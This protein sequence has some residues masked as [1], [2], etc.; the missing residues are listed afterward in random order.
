MKARNKRHKLLMRH[1]MTL[2]FAIPVI[3]IFLAVMAVSYRRISESYRTNIEYSLFQTGNQAVSFLES[4]FQGMWEVSERML[5]DGEIASVLHAEDFLAPKSRRQEYEEYQTL[6]SSMANIG[7]GSPSFRI[8]IYIP[9]SVGY[10]ANRYYIYPLSELG[11]RTEDPPVQDMLSGNGYVWMMGTERTAAGVDVLAT[12]RA[13]VLCRLMNDEAYGKDAS[14]ESAAPVAK[15]AVSEE[16]LRAILDNALILDG[17]SVL[18][19]DGRGQVVLAAGESGELDAVPE[20]LFAETES[21]LSRVR[22]RNKDMYLLSSPAMAYSGWRIAMTVPASRM[23]WLILKYTWYLIPLMLLVILSI[24]LTSILLSRVYT[25]RLEQLSEHMKRLQE[26]DLNTVFDVEPGASDE[27]DR[28]NE[29]FNYM[30]ER[31]RGLMQEHYRMGKSVKTSE[32]RALQAQINPHFLYNTLDLIN[33]MAMDFGTTEIAEIAQN[34]ARFYRLSLNRGRSILTIGEEIEHVEV[35]VNIEN[36][37]FNGAIEL[38]T[39]VSPDLLGLGCPNI[40]L[41]PFVENAI[42]HGIA[43]REEITECHIWISA[44]RDAD[45]VV[46]RIRD[47]GPGMTE[48]Q[49]RELENAGLDQATKGYGVKNI[50]FRLKLYFGEAYGIRYESAPGGGTTVTA[51]IPAMSVE[52]MEAY[53]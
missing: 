32:L 7:M 6:Y 17:E 43:E 48:E 41:Q 10:T 9:D 1:Q 36:F 45:D 25:S 46:F 22:I 20:E 13:L 19:A 40:I 18:I 27:F 52:E 31:I 44:G 3:L 15:V 42:V 50:N 23:R 5:E 35:Y 12:Y 8:S 30:A 53:C 29:G 4:Y 2:T 51:R 21:R 37:H 14:G 34:L 28:I 26:A 33:W 38:E 39:E 11:K 47:D 49:I 16:V 24:L